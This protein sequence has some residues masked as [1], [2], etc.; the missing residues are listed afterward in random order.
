MKKSKFYKVKVVCYNC[1]HECEMLIKKGQTVEKEK[2]PYCLTLS[3][4]PQ[5][6]H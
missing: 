3:L 1:G 5:V 4:I 2:C 6:S